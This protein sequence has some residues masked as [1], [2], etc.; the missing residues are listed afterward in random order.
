M[1]M[2]VIRYQSA[3]AVNNEILYMSNFGFEVV[4]FSPLYVLEWRINRK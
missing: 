2:Q 1:H 3:Y 4:N